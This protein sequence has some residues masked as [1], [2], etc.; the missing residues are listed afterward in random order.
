MYRDLHQEVTDRILAEL[1]KG[2]APWV[3]PW[4]SFAGGN[5]GQPVNALTNRPYSGC[6]V[7]LL[8]IAQQDNPAWTCARFVTFKQ[9]LELGG[10]VRKGEHGTKVYFW[11]PYIAKDRKPDADPEDKVK[12][13]V[14]REYTVFNV[15]QCE[16][17]PDRVTGVGPV[18][19]RNKCE[20]DPVADE[21]LTATGAVITEGQGEAAYYPS[22]DTIGL[23]AFAAFKDADNFYCTAFHELTHW[24]KQ[25]GRCDRKLTNKFG[26]AD[27]ALEELVAE[28]GAAFQCAEFGF[29]GDLRSAGYIQ[30]WISLLKDDKKAF[31]TAASAAQKAV[32]YLR[33]T[34]NAEPELEHAA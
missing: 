26:S 14:M 18:K 28:L 3:K 25:S 6:N 32:N 30:H 9:A 7:I 10:N 11:K 2:A 21:Y 33:D 29:D 20:R 27:Y 24:T 8:W 22:R 19:V 34:V 5:A 15:G 13:L 23:P 4:S 12:A 16:N 17:L 1:E 31:F